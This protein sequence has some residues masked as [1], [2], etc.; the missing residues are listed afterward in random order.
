[1]DKK[2]EKINYALALKE[3]C[4]ARYFGD[5]DKLLKAK[6]KIFLQTET[7]Q[8]RWGQFLACKKI[9]KTIIK[10]NENGTTDELLKRWS[11]EIDTVLN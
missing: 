6:E 7:F 8:G 11:Q 3:Y 9:K 1:M 2:R 4:C 10:A 5:N